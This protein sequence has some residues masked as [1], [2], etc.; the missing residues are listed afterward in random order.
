MDTEVTQSP[1]HLVKGKD[2]KA[3]MDC[4]PIKGHVHVYWYHKKPEGAF[5]FLV[6]L[7]NGKVTE[8]TAMYLQTA[9]F[10]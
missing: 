7:L 1:G 8:D 2:Q 4:V 3:K 9:I 6:Y 10:S 5:E